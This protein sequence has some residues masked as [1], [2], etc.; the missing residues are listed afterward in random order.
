MEVYHG[1]FTNASEAVVAVEACIRTCL[2]VWPYILHGSHTHTHM[3]SLD[4][5]LELTAPE[6]LGARHSVYAPDV[7]FHGVGYGAPGRA[8]G[9]GE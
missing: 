5:N 7:S 6:T 3:R 8:R 9:F 4:I 1:S 2:G